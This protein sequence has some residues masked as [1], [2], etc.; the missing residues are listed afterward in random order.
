MRAHKI[1]TPH[2]IRAYLG[3][4]AF[5][6]HSV[7][8]PRTSLTIRKNSTIKPLKNFINYRNNSL[9]IK[10]LLP[11]RR[12]K[13]LHKAKWTY[14]RF[15]I[16][17]KPTSRLTIYFSKWDNQTNRKEWAIPYQRWKPYRCAC[18]RYSEIR[19][20][21]DYNH[22]KSQLAVRCSVTL[23]HW[24]ACDKS[25]W[26][27]R[28]AERE[29]NDGKWKRKR[30]TCNGGGPGRWRPSLSRGAQ[31]F[32]VADPLLKVPSSLS[33]CVCVKGVRAGMKGG[34][35][36]IWIFE[37]RSSHYPFHI[38]LRLRVG[39]SWSNGVL[40]WPIFTVL[41]LS[42]SFLYYRWHVWLFE[43]IGLT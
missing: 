38:Y 24:T 3:P 2:N 43:S 14:F 17:L 22:C 13:N 26:G 40:I 33:F 27:V 37:I 36:E 31:T 8:F 19:R 12:T 1:N 18:R 6:F 32:S 7:C 16:P 39:G 41:P 23:R 10:I 35:F 20:L 30:R 5:P 9:V 42:F 28:V 15:A 4:F 29:N 34:E 21:L 25:N 11:S